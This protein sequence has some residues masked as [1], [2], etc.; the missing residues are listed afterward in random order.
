MA[1]VLGYP[2]VFSDVSEALAFLAD[3]A[4]RASS[5]PRTGFTRIVQVGAGYTP[6]I[7]FAVAGRAAEAVHDLID[8]LGPHQRFD[9]RRWRESPWGQD[10]DLKDALDKALTEVGGPEPKA[11]DRVEREYQRTVSLLSQPAFRG[12]TLEIASMLIRMGRVPADAIARIANR[13][14]VSGDAGD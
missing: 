3:P 14:G 11:W 12:A 9:V 1:V 13:W 4:A 6:D 8:D 10:D 2:L 7:S 5:F